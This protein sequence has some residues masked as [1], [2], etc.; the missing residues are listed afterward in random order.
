MFSA[1]GFPLST[2]IVYE[3]AVRGSDITP[4]ANFLGSF[5]P[6]NLK[7]EILLKLGVIMHHLT[8]KGFKAEKF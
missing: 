3:L 2:N 7:E 6:E 8:E 1:T 5:D 4:L